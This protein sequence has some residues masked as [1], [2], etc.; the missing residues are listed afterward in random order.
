[1]IGT[2]T[3]FCGFNCFREM[4]LHSL[5]CLFNVPFVDNAIAPKHALCLM[6]RD[7]HRDFPLYTSTGEI[8]RSGAPKIVNQ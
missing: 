1:M 3:G 4:C 7:L 2:I 8:P 5:R 6:A